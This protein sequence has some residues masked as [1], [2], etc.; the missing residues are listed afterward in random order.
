MLRVLIAISDDNL[1]I[2]FQDLVKQIFKEEGVQHFHF[3]PLGNADEAQ[4]ALK[5]SELMF[6]L[7]LVML[8]LPKGPATPAPPLSWLGLDVIEFARKHQFNMP[9]ALIASRLS[10]DHYSYLR[11]MV[12]QLAGS[13]KFCS[14]KDSEDYL[15]GHMHD[16]IRIVLERKSSKHRFLQIDLNLN[17]NAS[18]NWIVQGVGF[19][20]LDSYPLS[21]GEIETNLLRL[22]SDSFER[23][24]QMQGWE[25][26]HADLGKQLMHLLF[27]K[28]AKLESAIREGLSKAIDGEQSRSPLEYTRLRFVLDEYF[29]R[30]LWEALRFSEL[31]ELWM[32]FAPVYR[33]LSANVSNSSPFS[34]NSFAR[35]ADIYSCLLIDANVEEETLEVNG[36]RRTFNRLEHVA[37][38]LEA[39]KECLSESGQFEVTVL[40]KTGNGDQPY[41]EIVR[42]TLQKR[43]WDFV[44]FAGHSYYDK[45]KGTGAVLFQNKYIHPVYI[46]ELSQWLRKVGFVF[47][48]SCH[49]SEADF[50][51]S[52]VAHQVPAV[53]G[54]RCDVEDR[55][56]M[57]YASEFYRHLI[58]EHS[59]EIA[60][61]LA[62]KDMRHRHANNCIWVSPILIVQDGP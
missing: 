25:G 57:E 29:Y 58:K 60:Y 45:E 3:M 8:E 2:Y 61:Y 27:D 40:R 5:Y 41:S 30:I 52:L 20:Y 47:L 59:L 53:S 21:I 19:E 54:F 16:L 31:E 6:D 62:C 51:F 48:S 35:N 15:S 49:S 33:R 7:M 11:R 34:V 43:H 1:R 14:L 10:K 22:A 26:A 38:E 32:D 9:V 56:A 50:A 36:R 12:D 4:D 13:V 44:H 46:E 37:D 42:E 17:N 39:V 55:F 24:M 28:N 23:P 18:S